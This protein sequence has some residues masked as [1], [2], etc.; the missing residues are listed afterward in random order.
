MCNC[1]SEAIAEVVGPIESL[2]SLSLRYWLFQRAGT[3]ELVPL[4]LTVVERGIERVVQR[5][6]AVEGTLSSSALTE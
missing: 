6:E 3:D 1:V 5:E 4:V 2:W